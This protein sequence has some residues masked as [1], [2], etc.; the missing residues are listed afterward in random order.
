MFDNQKITKPIPRPIAHSRLGESLVRAGTITDEQLAAALEIQ[1]DAEDPKLRLGSVIVAQGFTS[2]EAIAHALADQLDLSFIDLMNTEIDPELIRLLPQKMAHKHQV[3]PLE[4]TTDKLLIA[5]SDPTNLTA[6]DDVKAATGIGRIELRVAAMSAVRAAID[7]LY[8]VD[9]AAADALDRLGISDEVQFV[10]DEPEDDAR[11]LERDAQAAPVIRLVNALLGDA[12]RG[13]AT[14]V[15]IE[16]RTDDVK[17]RYRIDGLLR[18]VMSLPRQVLPSVVSRIKIV[19]GMDIS[20]RRRPQDGR[21]KFVIDGRAID[22]RVSTMPTVFG[23][24]VVVRLLHKHES[25]ID[26]AALGLTDEHR[27]ILEEHLDRPQGLL[28]FTGPTGAGKSSTMYAAM[29]RLSAEER[30]LVSLE[31]PVEFQIPGLNQI[32]INERSGITFA[33]GLRSVLRQ[34]PDV[35]MVGEI[36]DVE[37]AQMVMQ[38]SF[39]GHMVLSSLHTRDAPGALTRLADLGVEPFR[40]AAAVTLVVAQRLVRMVCEKC[41][42]EVKA[43]RQLL[44]KLGLTPAAIAGSTFLQGSGCD[45]CAHTGYR[46]RTGIFE[47][48]PITAAVREQLTHGVSETAMARA[49]HGTGMTTLLEHGVQKAR[50]GITTLEEVHRVLYIERAE[51]PRCPSCRRHVTSSFVVCPYCRADL[52]DLPMPPASSL[53]VVGEGVEP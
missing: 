50:E 25:S 22:T 7:E 19:S 35:I 8:S 16:P 26:L 33:R 29:T 10:I 6:V 28:I 9:M 30:N 41:A 14:D 44:A 45:A 18:D 12:L 20:E 31:D 32:Q 2:E 24:K 37:T 27:V 23:E 34:D 49:A 36:R 3:V 48:F 38:A 52:T 46:G 40:I 5:I 15:H 11:A 1:H 42:I 51:G 43:D 21:N 17:V 53:K 4:Q 39:T 47:V 13:R